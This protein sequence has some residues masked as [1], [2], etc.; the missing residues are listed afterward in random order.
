MIDYFRMLHELKVLG[1]SNAEVARRLSVC[2]STVERWKLGTAKP[3]IEHGLHLV[4][5]YCEI[6]KPLNVHILHS[7]TLY[8]LVVTPTM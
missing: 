8:K 7:T 1:I 4:L 2:P 6:A 5:F 3:N